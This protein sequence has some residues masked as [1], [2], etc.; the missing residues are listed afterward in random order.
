MKNEAVKVSKFLSLVLRH[1]PSVIGMQLDENGWLNID[2][3]IRNANK[4]GRKLDRQLIEQ[5]VSENDK[6]RFTISSDGLYIRANQGHSVRTV[7]LELTPVAPPTQLFHGTVAD[8][9]ASIRTQGLLK[10]RRNHVH[11][12]ADIETATKVG[13]RRGKPM[14]LKVDSGRMHSSGHEFFLSKNGVWLTECV[15]VEFIVFP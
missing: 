3:L 8:F 10:R 12:S 1:R 13:S 4:D 9:V 7:N 15:P 2:D 5:V 6:Q 14:I 11:L